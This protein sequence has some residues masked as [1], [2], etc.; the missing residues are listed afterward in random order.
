MFYIVIEIKEG[1]DIC[2]TSKICKN[3]IIYLL[4]YK[5][6]K[7]K[8]KFKEFINFVIIYRFGGFF[9]LFFILNLVEIGVSN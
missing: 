3:K 9:I 5:L 7:V 8:E 4:L 1:I 6:I 2:D